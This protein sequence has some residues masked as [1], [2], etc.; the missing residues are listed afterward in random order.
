MTSIKQNPNSSTLYEKTKEE[1]PMIDNHPVLNEHVLTG[2]NLI[3]KEE[4]SNLV[5][6]VFNKIANI[7]EKSYGPFGSHTIINK[8]N[9]Q[10][11]TK[12]GYRIL[13]HTLFEG[14]KFYRIIHKQLFD[15]C[16]KLNNRVGDGTTTVILL[17]RLLNNVFNEDL[18][19]FIEEDPVGYHRQ[20]KAIMEAFEQ[21]VE[22]VCKKIDQRAREC[23]IDDIYNIAMIATNSDQK[24]SAIISELY[25][26][27]EDP[28]I[29]LLEDSQFGIRYETRDGLKVPLYLM[30]GVYINN[31]V[32]QTCDIHDANVIIFN[33]K[34]GDMAYNNIIYL[35][36]QEFALTNKRLVVI[37]PAYEESFLSGKWR[38][39][40]ADQLRH[41]GSIRTVLVKYN[42]T[43]LGSAGASDLSIFVDTNPIDTELVKTFSSDMNII[44]EN[45]RFYITNKYSYQLPIG[46][47]G[48]ARFGIENSYLEGLK[49]NE[50][51]LAAQQEKARI[52]YEQIEENLTTSEKEFSSKLSNAKKRYNRLLMKTCTIYYGAPTDLERE[53]LHDCIEDAIKACE[54][55]KRSGIVQS[56]HLEL[57]QVLS[58]I[59]YDPSLVTE[60]EYIEEYTK[61]GWWKQF[62]IYVMFKATSQLVYS[63]Y[64]TNKLLE[65][66]VEDN[67][68]Q[69]H[70]Q[71]PI[72]NKL[73]ELDQKYF[74][75]FSLNLTPSD[76]IKHRLRYM[77]AAAELEYPLNL[78]TL[79]PDESLITSADTDKE[80]LKASIELFKMLIGGNQMLYIL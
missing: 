19:V 21:A 4:Y 27:H 51:L 41:N 11:A 46:Y 43:I 57:I 56:Q 16:E 71:N 5:N 74:D 58:S 66:D 33:H 61:Y 29:Q 77:D 59:Q 12:D 45:N 78:L 47:I 2:L 9:Y 13:M 30:D 40:A 80:I 39:D 23:S 79:E 32:E 8:A 7:L 70:K 1:I 65:L 17:S 20:P 25:K 54:S 53:N 73:R 15:V 37:A 67:L 60:Q 52:E 42:P 24:I 75:I 3:T 34:I 62:A 63:L 35:L 22:T 72:L 50:L 55:A 18:K 31:T 14:D 44:F 6:F 36:E 10:F 69:Y 38:R 49:P 64:K 26:K 76:N 48:T 28:D 68:N